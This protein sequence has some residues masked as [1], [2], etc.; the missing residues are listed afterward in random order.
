MQKTGAGA[1]LYNTS[2]TINATT[3]LSP[4]A[5]SIQFNA[6]YVYD[7]QG[8][9][10][11]EYA[12]DGKLIS[13][14]VWFN[15]MPVATLRPKGSSAQLPLGISGTGAATANNI[16]NN[17]A[18]N[19]VNVDVYYLHPDHLGTPR[20][21]TRSVALN[22]ATTG[23]NAINK[24]VWRWDSD[25]FG[26][27]LGNSAPNENPQLVTGTATVVQAA[28]F[29]QSLRFP[30]QLA[31]NESAKYQNRYRDYDS[32]GRYLQ[33]DP[34]GLEAGLNTFAYV[35]NRPI[36]LK[37]PKGLA[38]QVCQYSI[39]DYP[40][41]LHAAICVDGNCRGYGPEDG[42][43]WSPNL[44]PKDATFCSK[45]DPPKFCDQKVYE[46]CIQSMIGGVGDQN[47][48][49]GKYDLL[50]R[51]CQQQQSRVTTTCFLRSCTA[52]RGNSK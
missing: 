31:D 49:D 52:P 50:L 37:D 47:I 34:I 6:R 26:T 22:G 2:A 25:P 13:E 45:Y 11:G 8:N 42:G 35:L 21:A 30:G 41:L 38:V 24:A 46:Q 18:A 10:I 20:A 33:S 29:K 3:G 43:A 36:S 28:T 48:L 7:E 51:N 5:A 23:P 4:L 12:P 17:T 1:Y 39:P 44:P 32:I 19:P 16:G 15:G 9:L 27:S 40:S 14:T